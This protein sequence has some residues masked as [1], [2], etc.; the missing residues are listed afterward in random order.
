[1]VSLLNSP[2]RVLASGF[3]LHM[4]ILDHLDCGHAMLMC[5]RIVLHVNAL[6][7]PVVPLGHL[8]VRIP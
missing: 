8:A 1:M 4:E 2:V 7:M 6:P 3:F 5:M